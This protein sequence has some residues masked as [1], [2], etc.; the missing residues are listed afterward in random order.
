MEITVQGDAEIIADFAAKPQVVTKAIV[1]ALN[2][3]IN[4]GRTVMVRA[5]AGDTGLKQADVRAALRMSEASF[6]R[7]EASLGASLK[8]IPLIKFGARGPRPSRGKG[9]GVTY[10]LKGGR[11]R[12]S[13][14][15]IARMAS[16]HE[17]VF[18]R[19]PGG[20]RRGPPP[21]RSQLPI[22]ELFGPSLGQVF[23]KHRPEGLARIREAFDKNFSHEL[24]FAKAQADAGTD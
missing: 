11:G 5:I 1:R 21:H 17:G 2:R 22:V 24:G 9:G 20:K 16:S 6:S 8:R 15:F 4:S 19:V 18:V 23:K 13:N 14:A 10:R 3:S 12:I 7:P